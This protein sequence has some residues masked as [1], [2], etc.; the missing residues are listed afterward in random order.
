MLHQV[1]PKG[2]NIKFLHPR[3]FWRNGEICES[4]IASREFI[5]VKQNFA[6]AWENA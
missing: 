4:K 5:E 3:N 2:K 1:L 6:L